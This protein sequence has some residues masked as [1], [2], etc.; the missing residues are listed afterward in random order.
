MAFLLSALGGGLMA[1]QATGP[2]GATAMQGCGVWGHGSWQAVGGPPPG[3]QSGVEC[4]HGSGP[5][6]WGAWGSPSV[7]VLI[8]AALLLCPTRP[9]SACISLSEG[10]LQSPL[11]PRMAHDAF[12]RSWSLT[13]AWPVQARTGHRAAQGWELYRRGVKDSER[14]SCLP[15]AAQ[16]AGRELGTAWSQEPEALSKPS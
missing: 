8:A 12:V 16:E 2:E 9:P 1:E 15:K 14:L 11:A 7:F 6:G 10:S 3:A 13:F 4:A 5:G